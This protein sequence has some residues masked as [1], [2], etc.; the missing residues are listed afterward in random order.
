MAQA[1]YVYTVNYIDPK[2]KTKSKILVPQTSVLASTADVA[3]TLA[4]RAIPAD[5]IE[6]LDLDNVEIIVRPF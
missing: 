1:Q 4:I 2:D 6:G 3:R 5:A